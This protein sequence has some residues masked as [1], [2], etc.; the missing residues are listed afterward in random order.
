ML[1]AVLAQPRLPEDLLPEPLPKGRYGVTLASRDKRPPA[2]FWSALDG[3]VKPGLQLA[4]TMP[5]DVFAWQPTATPAET[6]SVTTDPLS[7]PG[8][9]PAGEDPEQP[10]LRRRRANG[11]LLME[12]K[13]ATGDDA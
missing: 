12:G 13:R 6:I 8:I 2:D 10:V 7:R 9:P 5:F 1:K 4:V 11:A 3:R